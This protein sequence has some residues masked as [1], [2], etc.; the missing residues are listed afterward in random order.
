LRECLALIKHGITEQTAFNLSNDA[1]AAFL[2]IFGEL[3]GAE[4]NWSS[5]KWFEK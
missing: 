5:G 4:F 3:G 2:I 1:R